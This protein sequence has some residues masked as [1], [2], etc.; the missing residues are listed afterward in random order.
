[1]K[2]IPILENSVEVNVQ[3]KHSTLQNIKQM[4]FLV[5]KQKKVLNLDKS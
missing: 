1:M 2:V 3:K 4:V 5:K